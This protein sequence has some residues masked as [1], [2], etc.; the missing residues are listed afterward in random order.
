MST[1]KTI[2]T[3]LVAVKTAVDIVIKVKSEYEKGKKNK[4]DNKG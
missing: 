2:Q 1:I 3:A 4:W